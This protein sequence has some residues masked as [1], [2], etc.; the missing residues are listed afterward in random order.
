VFGGPLEVPDHA[1]GNGYAD[2]VLAAGCD[3]TGVVAG[4]GTDQTCS[5]YSPFVVPNGTVKIVMTFGMTGFNDGAD[6][7]FAIPALAPGGNCTNCSNT[8]EPATLVLLGT[9]LAA[10][11]YRLRRR[12]PAKS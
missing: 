3:P 1:N 2:Y 8:P 11:A 7:I 10:A 6:Q 12:R 9:G 4:A 5:K